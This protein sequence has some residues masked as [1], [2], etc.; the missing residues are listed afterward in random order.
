MST[1]TKTTTAP[2]FAA[3]AATTTKQQVA[4]ATNPKVLNDGNVQIISCTNCNELDQYQID[5]L[6]EQGYTNGK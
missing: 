1:K 2:T 5:R 3:T 4:P 6:M